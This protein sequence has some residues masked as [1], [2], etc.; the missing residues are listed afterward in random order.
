METFQSTSSIIFDLLGFSEDMLKTLE[1]A[2]VT[3]N[4]SLIDLYNT[5]NRLCDD[6][7]DLRA[8]FVSPFVNLLRGT[9]KQYLPRLKIIVSLIFHPRFEKFINVLDASEML[10]VEVRAIVFASF[11]LAYLPDYFQKFLFD[12]FRHLEKIYSKDSQVKQEK[13]RFKALFLREFG[14]PLPS[15]II[16]PETP[17]LSEQHVAINIKEQST[18][19]RISDLIQ[20]IPEMNNLEATIASQQILTLLHN[21]PIDDLQPVIAS[22]KEVATLFRKA[23][24][25]ATMWYLTNNPAAKDAQISDSLRCLLVIHMLA[26]FDYEALV[27]FV[28]HCGAS[29]VQAISN[30]SKGMLAQLPTLIFQKYVRD[31]L[32]VEHTPAWGACAIRATAQEDAELMFQLTETALRSQYTDNNPLVL[33]GLQQACSTNPHLFSESIAL[34]SR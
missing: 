4:S 25:H 2:S 21:I 18:E 3:E 30:L 27:P 29:S 31:R 6:S 7:I 23:F 17:V 12:F 10:E 8:D 14:L 11:N 9:P 13:K 19:E 33:V 34:L 32:S 1:T 16:D 24:L 22:L 15:F 26:P 28:F 5:L 20:L